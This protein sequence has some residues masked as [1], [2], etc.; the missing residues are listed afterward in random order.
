[1]RYEVMRMRALHHMLW[2]PPAPISPNGVRNSL[3]VLLPL[4]LLVLSSAV[5]AVPGKDDILEAAAAVDTSPPIFEIDP[6]DSYVMKNKPATLTCRAQHALKVY[7]KCSGGGPPPESMVETAFNEPS[8]GMRVVEAQVDVE[9][10]TV[11]EYFEDYQCHCVA[12]S[13]RGQTISKTSKISTAFLRR[14]FVEP[15]YSAQVSLEQ[16]VELRCLP[17]DGRP[18]PTTIWLKNGESIVPQEHPNL[19][20]S[21][22][23]SLLF[24]SARL[25]DSA[26]YSCI[27]ENVAAKRQSDV[28]V[29]KI[30]VDGAWSS[31]S[32]W[33]PCNNRC[34]RGQQRRL[35]TCTAP[36]PM[37]G[38][39]SCQGPAMQKADC[40]QLCPAVHG[41][42]SSWSSWSTCSPDCR[43]HRLRDC[44]GP[45][46]DHGGRDCS[47]DHMRSQNCTGGMCRRAGTSVRIYGESTED[48]TTTAMQQ[49]ITLIIVLAVLIPL[50]LVLLVIV[51]KK[52]NRK[53]RHEG[54]IYKI[55]ASDY[56]HA[57]YTDTAKKQKSLGCPDLTSVVGSPLNP[58]TPLYYDHSY[59]DPANV[60]LDHKAKLGV[61]VGYMY[62][63]HYSNP[64]SVSSEHHYDVPHLKS[65]YDSPLHQESAHLLLGNRGPMGTPIIER[66]IIGGYDDSP[67]SS[68]E[69]P[70]R[71]EVSSSSSQASKATIPCAPAPRSPPPPP[72]LGGM[73]GVEGAAWGVVTS[74]GGRLVIPEC[75][76]TL[77]IP[78]GALAPDT[79][80]ELYVAVVPQPHSFPN[81]NER[82]TLLSPVICCGPAGTMLL[83]PAI[84]SLEHCASLQHASWQL[85]V[86]A[87]TNLDQ[88][89]TN[90]VSSASSNSS[91]S[92]FGRGPWKKCFTI[93]EER[94]DTPIFTQ[95]DGSQVHMLIDSL[96]QL[97]LVGESASSS[98]AVKQ[99]KVVATAPPPSADGMLQVTVNIMQDTQAALHG[100]SQAV[101]RSGATLLDKPKTLLVQD[102][103]ANICLTL[104][105]VGP[106]W[107]NRLGQHYQELSFESVWCAGT[108][109]VSSRFCLE[110]EEG[111]T[112]VALSC[113]VVAQQKGQPNNRQVIRINTD[114]PYAPVT[115]SPAHPTL[116][117]STVT[118]SS[119][120]SSLVTLTPEPNTFRLPHRLRSELCRCLD[121]PNARG[122][123]WRM[124][125]ARLNVDRYLNYFACKPSPTEHILD[126]WE[127]RHREPTAVT[128]LLNV[129][130]VMGRPDAAHV[131]ESHSGAWI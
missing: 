46:P 36:A 116:R 71:S 12:W 47:G 63:E 117:T 64:A 69:K 97:V 99:V 39:A 124:L 107:R 88:S 101:K 35:R 86:F 16:Q 67:M 92:S 45:R 96:Q 28:A 131:L 83:K 127:A 56:S 89:D 49:D 102:C 44:N 32:S 30:F 78:E 26:N 120:C 27:A 119:G 15:P 79:Q 2:G 4:A 18:T 62:D 8:T 19:R 94:V 59:S 100:M 20:I 58:N 110:R 75:G 108:E 118:T 10:A 122:N 48:A 112:S 66:N 41:G 33:S 25:E 114:F 111:T 9:R 74:D 76:V 82:Q 130:R 123:D 53:N 21:S 23:G 54:P 104:D 70:A 14:H 50:I 77:T 121:P 128:D 6:V 87:S 90:T 3:W 68:L 125:A 129:L 61:D 106:G 103:G 43:H 55:A 115:A 24:L 72:E 57:L 17:P 91:S 7:F 40:T 31:W 98:S 51:F 13:S 22:E 5:D 52:F 60:T 73:A 105:D 113:R 65:T 37:N 84:L 11:E 109:A 34:G 85:H 29:L 80:E 93:G 81:L 42:W 95:L 126:L 38:G 1:M